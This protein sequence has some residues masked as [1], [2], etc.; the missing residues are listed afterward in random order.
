MIQQR[1]LQ[2]LIFIL[3]SFGFNHIQSTSLQDTENEQQY[4]LG[5]WHYQYR[6]NPRYYDKALQCLEQ[7][8]TDDHLGAQIALSDIYHEYNGFLTGQDKSSEVD[9]EWFFK[10]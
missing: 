3:C 8:A 6:D 5:M 7:A 10:L 1:F 9:L 2:L 4:R